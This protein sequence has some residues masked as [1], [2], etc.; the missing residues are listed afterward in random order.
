MIHIHWWL[1]AFSFCFT[2]QQCCLFPNLWV[3]QATGPSL[4]FS[5]AWTHEIQPPPP[6]PPPVSPEYRAAC[7]TQADNIL[8]ETLQYCIL[9]ANYPNVY[10]NQ[11]HNMARAGVQSDVLAASLFMG[12]W[13]LMILTATQEASDSPE[14]ALC[15]EIMEVLFGECSRRA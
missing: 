3:L 12:L 15:C 6:P 1:E 2:S 13:F 5:R 10:S 9:N 11:H 8:K 7:Q 4:T 14:W